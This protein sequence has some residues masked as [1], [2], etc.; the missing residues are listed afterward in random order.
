MAINWIQFE[1][2]KRWI[3]KN[4]GKLF[5]GTAVT[6]KVDRDNELVTPSINIPPKLLPEQDAIIEAAQHLIAICR[7]RI[8]IG[9]ACPL[10]IQD[11]GQQAS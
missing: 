9:D 3:N 6:W 1:L 5:P 8:V 2:D 10:G 11:G 4:I 7:S